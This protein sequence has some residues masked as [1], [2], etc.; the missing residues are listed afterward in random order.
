MIQVKKLEKS[1]DNVNHLHILQNLN[2]TE[3]PLSPQQ[4]WGE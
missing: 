4:S 1:Y 2:L 3:R